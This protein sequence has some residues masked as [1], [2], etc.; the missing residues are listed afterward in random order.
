MRTDNGDESLLNMMLVYIKLLKHQ[1]TQKCDTAGPQSSG[2]V[3][4]QA[5]AVLV[6]SAI[7]LLLPQETKV[8]QTNIKDDI[9]LKMSSQKKT[10][11][12]FLF[13]H[14]QQSGVFRKKKKKSCQKLLFE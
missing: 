12:G 4:V 7:N 10:N 1:K 8:A 5:G 14:K 9:K 11:P 3:N 13:T 2:R 6:P